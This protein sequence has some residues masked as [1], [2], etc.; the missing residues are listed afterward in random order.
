MPIIIMRE[1]SLTEED[2]QM[3]AT[4]ISRLEQLVARNR[5]TEPL[6]INIDNVIDVIWT[7]FTAVK[8][9]TFTSKDGTQ[10]GIRINLNTDNEG[11]FLVGGTAIPEFCSLCIDAGFHK[12]YTKGIDDGKCHWLRESERNHNMEIKCHAF[13]VGMEFKKKMLE[14]NTGG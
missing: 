7:P 6:I 1:K 13:R 14:L 3:L 12:Q 10:E 5:P 2:A 8:V 4:T 11:E 9:L